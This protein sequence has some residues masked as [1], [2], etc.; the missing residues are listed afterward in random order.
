MTNGQRRGVLYTLPGKGWEAGEGVRWGAEEAD[1]VEKLT[2]PLDDDEV[3]TYCQALKAVWRWADS[4]LE[5]K[6]ADAVRVAVGDEFQRLGFVFVRD[7]DGD[8]ETVH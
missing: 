5:R 2:Y 3:E 8:G 4:V 6:T 1:E 7:V